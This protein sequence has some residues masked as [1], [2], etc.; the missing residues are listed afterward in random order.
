[1]ATPSVLPSLSTSAMPAA[2]LFLSLEGGVRLICATTLALVADVEVVGVDGWTSWR[3]SRA[4]TAA[5]V[6]GVE[7]VCFLE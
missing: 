6:A 1:M 3:W 5:V 2:L 7:A 4:A